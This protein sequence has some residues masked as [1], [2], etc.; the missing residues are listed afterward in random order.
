MLRSLSTRTA[1]VT[2]SL[3]VAGLLL[4]TAGEAVAAPQD[5]TTTPASQ[6]QVAGYAPGELVV[7]YEPGTTRTD[8]TAVRQELG[9]AVESTFGV[10]GAEVLDL[11]DGAG[12]ESAVAAAESLPD[13]LYAEPNYSVS[14]TASPN[15]PMFDEMWSLGLTSGDGVNSGIGTP[16]VWNLTTGSSGVT[17]GVVDTG[18]D[19]THPDLANNMYTNPGEVPGNGVDDDGNGLVDD[20]RGWDWV[21]DD[22]NAADLNGHGTHVAGTIGAKGNNA[23]GVVGVAWEVRLV[24]LRVLD[25]AGSGWTSDVA[26][27]FAYA[28]RNGVD[29][30]NA[31]LAGNSPSVA[32]LDAIKASPNTLFVVAAGNSTTNVDV[33]P[34]YPCAYPLPNVICVAATDQGNRL[35]NY[36]NYGAAQ[37]DLAAPGDRILSTFPGG[38]YAEMT[39]TSMATPHVAGVAALLRA[40]HPEASG[41]TIKQA[42]LSGSEGLTALA[43]RTLS[44]GRLSAAGAFEQMGDV[45]PAEQA[46]RNLSGGDNEKLKKSCK[47]H[48]RHGHKGRKLH[49]RCRR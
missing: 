30:V 43:G 49:R 32:L 36:S 47:R 35:S 16:R 12:V 8:R 18:V 10:K 2:A 14:T 15:D 29:V 6:P 27:A 44:G 20:V 26:A 28:G 19:A 31:S 3:V 33:A 9:A 23:N 17:V 42:I 1:A 48:R 5:T 4:G 24:P 41:T 25:A 40:R 45:V 37:V 13:V 39:G 46:D 11:P 34:T 38:A 21:E 22:N 7:R